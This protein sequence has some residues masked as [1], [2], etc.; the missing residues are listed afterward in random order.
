MGG[1]PDIEEFYDLPVLDADWVV[2]D[3][4]DDP[5]SYREV[6]SMFLKDLPVLRATLAQGARSSSA[7][8]I[9]VIHEVANSLGVIGAR[10]G[11]A[12][13]RL[14]E[15]RLRE[16]AQIDLLWVEQLAVE[17]LALAEEAL[18]AWMSRPPG[19]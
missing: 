2:R 17:A 12:R 15:R 7:A 4:G 8:L 13:V 11:T 5:E 3:M 16:G 18:L 19:P 9:S 6:A 14:A 10:R 1:M